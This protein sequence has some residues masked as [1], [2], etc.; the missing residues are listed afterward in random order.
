[1]ILSSFPPATHLVLPSRV[2]HF[3][4]EALVEPFTEE[5]VVNL[6]DDVELLK[7]EDYLHVVES[8][9]NE[10][11]SLLRICPPTILEALEEKREEQLNSN[12]STSDVSNDGSN[13]ANV[14]KEQN[15]SS[16]RINASSSTIPLAYISSTSGSG[17]RRRKSS[18]KK[19]VFDDPEKILDLSAKSSSGIDE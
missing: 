5:P 15:S 9:P 11:S 13:A 17:S 18:P 2:P 12:S 1:M 10:S 4:V 8:G 6:L 14:H 3:S 16:G 19:R 7:S